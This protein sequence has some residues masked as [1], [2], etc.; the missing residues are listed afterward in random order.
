M[1]RIAFV[2]SVCI[3]LLLTSCNQENLMGP[4]PDTLEVQF[5]MNDME[6][7]C[8]E[9]TELD[10]K[11]LPQVIQDYLNA[12]FSNVKLDDIYLLGDEETPLYGIEIEEDISLLFDAG[13]NLLGQS[14]EEE[15]NE[16]STDQLPLPLTEFLAAN[17]PEAKIDEAEQESKYGMIFIEVELDNEVELIFDAEGNFLCVDDD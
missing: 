3:V 14:T 11:D 15:E 10:E 17:Y 16:L 5:K 4:D 9:G 2:F 12:N 7:F 1:T 6:P 8:P 13:G